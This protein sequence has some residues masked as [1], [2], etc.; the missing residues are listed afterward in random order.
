M[1]KLWVLYF[2]VA[3]ASVATAQ[4]QSEPILKVPGQ[5]TYPP[6]ARQARI[7]GQ[8]KLEFVVNQ[9]GEPVSVTTISGHP[10]LAPS[11]EAA[12]WTW[13]FQIPKSESLEDLHLAT[14]FDYELVDSAPNY[15]DST[16]PPAVFNSF[17]H[18]TVGAIPVL[19][20]DAVLTLVCPTEQEKASRI[21]DGREF[22]ELAYTHCYETVH[23]LG[24]TPLM[25]AATKREA[26]RIKR[27][28]RAGASVLDTDSNGWT[29]LM[30]AAAS[31]DEDSIEALLA[32]GANANQSSLFG[33][34]PLMISATRG[35]LYGSLLRAVANI[36]AKNSAGTTTLMIL[37]AGGDSDE[38]ATALKAGADPTF[39][40]K[41]NRTAL[42]YLHL[43]NCG[44]SPLKE[45]PQ[46]AKTTFS[47]KACDDLNQ[48]DVVEIER[49]LAKAMHRTQIRSE[50][51]VALAL[52]SSITP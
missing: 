40:D 5:P 8:V 20:S 52:S 2:L 23:K 48:K 14:T 41:M 38:V 9:D 37:A 39:Q 7:Q 33:N 16:P 35:E 50:S 10:M 51:G 25:A 49:L 6:L 45:K 15:S 46:E 4:T 11:A 28:L 21:H 1:L 19:I 32:G 47:S 29:A 3:L 36:D 26:A 42:D 17:H 34:S 18:V 27:L 22:V 44:S 12:I 31:N 30:Y 13:R 24:T 43:A